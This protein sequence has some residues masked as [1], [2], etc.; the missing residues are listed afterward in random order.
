MH[1]L[2][3]ECARPPWNGRSRGW[4]GDGVDEVDT[5]IVTHDV[6]MAEGGGAEAA[7]ERKKDRDA[8][9]VA[10]EMRGEK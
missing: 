4:C 10:F 2:T 7:G 6:D 3:V 1:L 8:E 5:N 9:R